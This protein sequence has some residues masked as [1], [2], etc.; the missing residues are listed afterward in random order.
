[1]G[2]FVTNRSDVENSIKQ[3]NWV[4]A[5]SQRELTET[6]A[7]EALV[8]AGVSIYTDQPEVLF[9]YLDELVTE[10]IDGLE[11]AIAQTLESQ[12]ETEVE[13]FAIPL[14]KNFLSGRTAG[15]QSE[16]FGD[17]GIKAGVAQFIGHNE[18]FNP[19]ANPGGILGGDTGAWQ[20]IGPNLI[21]Y[22]P[23]VGLRYQSTGGGGGGGLA[24]GQHAP[25][26]LNRWCRSV[27]GP[28][29]SAVLKTHNVDGWVCR[30]DGTDFP[31]DV[32]A[33]AR[34][35]YGQNVNVAYTNFNDPDSWYA[36]RE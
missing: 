33:A 20:Q 34:M 17:Y 14:I 36:Y 16:N 28:N 3:G 29:A 11:A 31:I 1:M 19:V 30:L 35:E 18:E 12:V 6:D 9:A 5:F 7:L 22:C 23:Y 15:E 13:N 21:S 24:P 25:V 32:Q 10:S 2:R 4:V 27:H 8:A 26:D